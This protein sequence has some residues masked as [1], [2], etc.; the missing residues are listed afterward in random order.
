[1]KKT[2]WIDFE[3]A[4]HVWIFKEFLD[5]F[6]SKDIDLLLTARNFS[7]TLKLC[8][9]FKLDVENIS[10]TKTRKSKFG[11]VFYVYL[12]A[13]SLISYFR[14]NNLRAD[15][16]LSHG[17]RSG[18]YAAYKLGIPAVSLDDYEY[19]FKGF[20]YFVKELMTPNV[21][22]AEQWGVFKNKVTQYPGLKEELYLWNSANY[23]YEEVN[24]LQKDKINIVFRPE[25][26]YSHYRSKRSKVVQDEILKLFKGL[27]NI[28]IILIPRDEK[29]KRK[30]CNYFKDNSI[31]F[32][33]PENVVNGPALLYRSDL[34]IGGG[35]TMTRE[36]AILNV[37][38]YTFFGGKLGYAD[39]FLI[40]NSKLIFISSPNEIQKIVFKKKDKTET[41]NVSKLGY[42][43]IL[44]HLYKNYLK[45]Y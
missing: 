14:E 23:A 7:A 20:N 10:S 9:Y 25:G 33:V 34:V 41:L 26:R 21:I 39:Q 2:I 16:F 8:N 28:F 36:S 24:F 43:F 1:M 40:K 12:R 6:K 31:Q 15:L 37:S 38:S 5:E 44:N 30:I 17:S 13:K 27:D 11:K 18:S 4:P 29:Q 45:I 22:P 3:N 35:G 19:S 42:D 32:I